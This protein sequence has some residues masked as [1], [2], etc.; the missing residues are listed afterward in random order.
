MGMTSGL[1][2]DYA[3]S[4]VATDGPLDPA[5][6]WIGVFQSLSDN[7]LATVLSDLVM[8]T[9]SLAT[10]LPLTSWAGPYQLGDGSIY[11][12]SPAKIFVPA[13]SADFSNIGGWYLA[14]A[15][16]AGELL[17][18]SVIYPSIPLVTT[19]SALTILVR[20]SVPS[21]GTYDVSIDVD[22]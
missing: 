22:G 16:T 10:R 7:G 17:Y 15:L 14:D 9:G 2:A 6:T 12:E 21:I 4:I 18:Y 5:A 11:Y 20:M 3:A 1:L 19:M 8:P 13:T